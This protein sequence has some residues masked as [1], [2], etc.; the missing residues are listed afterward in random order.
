MKVQEPSAHEDRTWILRRMGDRGGSYIYRPGERASII[1]IDNKPTIVIWF[2]NF[3]LLSR[4]IGRKLWRMYL[5][6]KGVDY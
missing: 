5:W 4:H 1:D 3:Q 6:C 2:Y